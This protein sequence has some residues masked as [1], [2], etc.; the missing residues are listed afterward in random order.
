MDIKTKLLIVCTTVVAACSPRPPQEAVLTDEYP[1]IFPFYADSVVIPPNIAP[2]NFV[3]PDSMNN[4]VVVI[5][6][7]PQSLNETVTAFRGNDIRIPIKKWRTLCAPASRKTSVVSSEIVQTVIVTVYH[8][9]KR[10]KPLNW[11]V[12]SDSIDPRIVYR[13]VL[14]TDGVYQTISVNERELSSFKTRPVVQNTAIKHSCFNCHSFQNYNGNRMILQLR[15]PRGLL[16]KDENGTRAVIPPSMQSIKDQMIPDEDV[17]QSGLLYS[18][19]HPTQNHIVFSAG[20][21][22]PVCFYMPAGEQYYY[23]Q[24]ETNSCLVSYNNGEWLLLTHDDSEYSYPAWHPDG[25][26]LFF[27]R[28]TKKPTQPYPDNPEWLAEYSFDICYM[29]YDSAA[30]KFADTIYTLV[31]A[32]DFAKDLERSR[33]GV[34]SSN[35]VYGR[36]PPSGGSFG[37]PRVSPDGTLLVATYSRHAGNPVRSYGVLAGIPLWREDTHAPSSAG[38]VKPR[39]LSEISDPLG[40]GDSWASFSSNGKWLMFVSKRVDG[41]FTQVYFS[42]ID[43]GGERRVCENFDIPAISSP[44]L[45]PQQTGDYYRRASKAFN[46]PEFITTETAL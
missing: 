34:F 41:Y 4:A 13:L 7:E 32:A 31:K 42:H 33:N 30:R 37:V 29:R 18:S 9:G 25:R 45:L 19:W 1:P 44:F 5:S 24:S 16:I 28:S 23:N 27:V 40:R 36:T 22:A 3:L 8:G 6:N 11:L 38:A 21:R 12:S 17:A 43:E 15:N 46:L 2:L 10:Y 26:T 35:G 14:P 39:I 20:S